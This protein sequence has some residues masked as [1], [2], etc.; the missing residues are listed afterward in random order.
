MDDYA[1]HY[2]RVSRYGA[3]HGDLRS[4]L[5]AARE[6]PHDETVH[7]AVADALDEVHPGHP[8]A[9]LLRRQFGLGEHGGSGP[10]D[11]LWYEPVENSWDGSFPYAARLGKDAHFGYYLRHESPQ[12]SGVNPITSGA[13]DRWVLHA[14]SQHPGSKDFGYSFEFGHDEAHQIPR[15]LPSASAHIE[16]NEMR[17]DFTH[18]GR[19]NYRD[20]EAGS[21]DAAMDREENERN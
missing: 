5:K 2:S 20:A 18:G 10:R 7:H 14:V 13:N 16:P 12:S 19:H 11:N 15:L 4:L 21:F 6:N 9:A 17:G 1:K 3:G 8:V